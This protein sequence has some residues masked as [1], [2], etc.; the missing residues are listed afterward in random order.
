M[1]QYSFSENSTWS[2]ESLELIYSDLLELSALSYSKYKWVI[3]FLDNYSSFC[4][5][6]FL[7]KRSETVDTIRSIFQM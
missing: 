4:N 3:T 5:I 6:T 7:C 2:S 1:H